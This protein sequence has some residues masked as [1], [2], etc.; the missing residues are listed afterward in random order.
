VGDPAFVRFMEQLGEETLQGLSTHD[1][2]VLDLLRREQPLN[3]LL[4]ARLPRLVELG[5]V[6]STGRG[7]GVRYL[8]SQRLYGALGAKGEYTRKKGLDRETNKALLLLHIT[9]NAAV[10]SS[11]AEFKQVLPALGRGQVQALVQ[12]LADEGRVHFVGRTKAAR[13]F[14]APPSQAE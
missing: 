12:E 1:F 10:G 2:L 6:E 7:K 13:W 3:D 5:A 9:R 14:P 8:L 4:L 11:L